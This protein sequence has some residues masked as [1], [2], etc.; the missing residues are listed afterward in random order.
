MSDV[1]SARA[2]STYRRHRLTVADYHRMGEVGVFA[3]DARVELI[4]GEVIDM[5]PIGSR[6][7][8]AVNYFTMHLVEALQRSA[9]VAVQ[10]PVALDEHTEVQP[11]VA[12]LRMRADLYGI[13]HPRPRDV[14]LIIEV[15]DTTVRYDLDVKLPL[16]ARA[17]IAEVWVVDLE[18][19]VLRLFR[20]PGGGDY[21]EKQELG[22]VGAMAIPHLPAAT[23]DLSG[24][25]EV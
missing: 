16:Y 1:M 12:V 13:S 18:V 8:R 7:A 9:V 10:N 14:L 3:H 25:F 20:D 6:H 19:G 23:I 5:A 11:D 22:R 15:A 24:L 4:E 2:E 17:G 21:R